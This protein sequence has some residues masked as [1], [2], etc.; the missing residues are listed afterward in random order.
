MNGNCLLLLVLNII[1][2]TNYYLPTEWNIIFKFYYK[3]ETH[4][5]L[6][7]LHKL[8]MLMATHFEVFYDIL[9]C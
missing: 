9:I 8:L 3:L 1:L 5:L 7:I 4:P 6:G 2:T